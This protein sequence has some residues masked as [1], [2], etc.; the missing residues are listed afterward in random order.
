MYLYILLLMDIFGLVPVFTIINNA[1]L[2]ILVHVLWTYMPISIGC[3]TRRDFKCT[4]VYF[5]QQQMRV[6]VIDVLTKLGI[7]AFILAILMGV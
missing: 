7:V 3:V 4:N 2:N 1:S 6:V 5:Q